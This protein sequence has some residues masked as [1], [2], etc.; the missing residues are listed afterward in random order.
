MLRLPLIFGQQPLFYSIIYSLCV[1][2]NEL[3]Q[4]VPSIFCVDHIHTSK[5]LREHLIKL[6][7][8]T[9]TLALKWLMI[10]VSAKHIIIYI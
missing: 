8:L 5:K 3:K 1:P 2:G 9:L 7:D 4:A 6:F 10:L